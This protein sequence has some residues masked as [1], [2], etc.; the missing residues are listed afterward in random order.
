MLEFRLQPAPVEVTGRVGLQ[1]Y[2]ARQG[3]DQTDSINVVILAPRD[4][5]VTVFGNFFSQATA[6]MTR[7]MHPRAFRFSECMGRIS[8]V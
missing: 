3:P 5:A 1:W 8:I 4:E 2:A 6:G 7:A